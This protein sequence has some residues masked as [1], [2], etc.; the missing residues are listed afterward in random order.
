MRTEAVRSQNPGRI[1]FR[2]FRNR[3]KGERPVDLAASHTHRILVRARKQ[4]IEPVAETRLPPVGHNQG[5][6][7][8][9]YGVN[10]GATDHGDIGPRDLEEPCRVRIVQQSQKQMLERDITM[11]PLLGCSSGAPQRMIQI[12]GTRQLLMPCRLLVHGPTTCVSGA[13][14]SPPPVLRGAQIFLK[15]QLNRQLLRKSN[16][17]SQCALF[18]GGPRPLYIPE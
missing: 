5:S 9:V 1:A 15:L 4:R 8:I 13:S 17:P 6:H 18:P 10:H 2:I 16:G 7:A 11:R 14:H 12:C 3:D